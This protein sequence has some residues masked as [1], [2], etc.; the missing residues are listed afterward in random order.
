MAEIPAG[1]AV[2][3]ASPSGG[4]GSTD[5]N[6]TGYGDFTHFTKGCGQLTGHLEGEEHDLAV[7]HPFVADL[8]I[9]LD[10]QACGHSTQCHTAPKCIIK[11]SN[12]T[13]S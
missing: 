2:G 12:L 7:S 5:E 10:D 9:I 6:G 11:T 4:V 3:R 8:G 1:T 13:F